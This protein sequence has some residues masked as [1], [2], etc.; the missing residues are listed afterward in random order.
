MKYRAKHE[1]MSALIDL[2][3]QNHAPLS[4]SKMASWATKNDL[5]PVPTLYD[6]KIR[7]QEWETKFEQ[8]KAESERGGVPEFTLASDLDNDQTD[9]PDFWEDYDD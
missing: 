2:Y 9:D 1:R 6:G 4:I 8:V 5:W 7:W 3:S